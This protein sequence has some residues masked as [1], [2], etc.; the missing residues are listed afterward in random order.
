MVVI[1][2]IRPAAA[3]HLLVMPKAHIPNVDSL[4]ASDVHLGKAGASL[5][6]RIAMLLCENLQGAACT[7]CGSPHCC[8]AVPLPLP[9]CAQCVT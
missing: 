3:V 5:C 6:A 4:A 7:C 8:P 2:D 9:G 1:P